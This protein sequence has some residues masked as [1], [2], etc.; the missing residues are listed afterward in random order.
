MKC[1][2]SGDKGGVEQ[3]QFA[4][5]G[6]GD[7][8]VVYG[9]SSGCGVGEV[10]S[11]TRFT[12][13]PELDGGMAVERDAIE[14]EG[15]SLAH[16]NHGV[17]VEFQR[18]AG[19]GGI[20][21]QNNSSSVDFIVRQAFNAQLRAFHDQ[22]AIHFSQMAHD[23]GTGSGILDECSSESV[24]FRVPAAV[25]QAAAAR[26]HQRGGTARPRT[27][28]KGV[29]VRVGNAAVDDG[30]IVR[31]GVHQD[32]GAVFGKNVVGFFPGHIAVK[33][34]SGA[35]Q[36]KTV[37]HQM[38]GPSQSGGGVVREGD[39]FAYPDIGAFIFK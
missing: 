28:V 7:G 13:I 25:E 14:E 23:Q 35:N 24:V 37:F 29:V 36:K 9:R 16:F 20:F 10:P 3:G 15:R 4:D 2:V 21:R 38:D 31:G 6:S 5:V 11:I 1:G 22:G 30:D 17:S 27:V 26:L 8:D 34:G 18:V 39:I 32:D 33:E 12:G 19:Q